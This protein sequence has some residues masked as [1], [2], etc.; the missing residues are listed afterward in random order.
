MENE[1]K[2][3]RRKINIVVKPEKQNVTGWVRRSRAN[4]PREK[5]TPTLRKAAGGCGGVNAET[6]PQN[7]EGEMTVLGRREAA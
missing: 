2:K 6:S 3:S 7:K 5:Q 1:P 4:P